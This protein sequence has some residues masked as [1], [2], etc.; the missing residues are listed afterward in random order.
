MLH[1]IFILSWLCCY[2]TV[3]YTVILHITMKH[4]LYL[5]PYRMLGTRGKDYC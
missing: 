2:L 3:V 1:R 5:H 4:G